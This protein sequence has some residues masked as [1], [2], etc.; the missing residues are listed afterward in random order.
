MMRDRR[1]GDEDDLEGVTTVEMI[2]LIGVQTV[3]PARLIGSFL[4][5]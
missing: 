5:L 2:E 1:A 4:D 3:Q